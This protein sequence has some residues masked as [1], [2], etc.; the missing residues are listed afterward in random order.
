MPQFAKAVDLLIVAR[1]K[2]WYRAWENPVWLDRKS[3]RRWP[4][5][6]PR[7]F[8]SIRPKAF[9]ET[10]AC[11]AARDVLIAISNSGET[12]EMLQLLP[13]VERMGIPVSR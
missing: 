5:R 12:Q 7:R 3:L 6:A 13:Y 8:F 4:A 1:A 9:M 11:W 10:S 2:S